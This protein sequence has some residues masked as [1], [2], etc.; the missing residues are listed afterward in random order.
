MVPQEFVDKYNLKYK[1]KNEYILAR[2][3][4]GM[5][6]TPRFNELYMMY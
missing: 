6:I 5:H 2:V 3:T 1:V 4:K